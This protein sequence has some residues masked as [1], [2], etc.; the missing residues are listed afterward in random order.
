MLNNHKKFNTKIL[1]INSIFKVLSGRALYLGQKPIEMLSLHSFHRKK[2]YH[3]EYQK[4]YI[5]F[6]IW[7]S[8]G[9]VEKSPIFFSFFDILNIIT[10]IYILYLFIMLTNK[11]W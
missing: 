9:N 5:S 4:Y 10:M 11:K 3:I 1:H 6:H 8:S 2:G 7:K